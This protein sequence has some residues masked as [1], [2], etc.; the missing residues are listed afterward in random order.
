MVQRGEACRKIRHWLQQ[1]AVQRLWWR[2]QTDVPEEQRRRDQERLSPHLAI[3]G[4]EEGQEA[5]SHWRQQRREME[6]CASE[7]DVEEWRE[8]SPRRGGPSTPPPKC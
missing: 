2:M 7:Q 5:Q 8:R 1:R 4:Q 6:A 3:E